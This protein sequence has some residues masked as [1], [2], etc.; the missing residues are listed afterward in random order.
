MLAVRGKVGE[1]MKSIAGPQAFPILFCRGMIADLKIAGRCSLYVAR[2]GSR[3]T[4]RFLDS[5]AQL[6]LV[7]R[8][9]PD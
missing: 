3:G 8:S 7:S 6:A 1:D 2:R 9:G 4:L 5:V